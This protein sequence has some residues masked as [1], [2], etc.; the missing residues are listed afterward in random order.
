MEDSGRISLL[1]LLAAEG[2]GVRG[3]SDELRILEKWKGTAGGCLKFEPENEGG[4]LV[5]VDTKG[6]GVIV[7]FERE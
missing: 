4:K 7:E 3:V 6:R 2:G 1:P 5:A